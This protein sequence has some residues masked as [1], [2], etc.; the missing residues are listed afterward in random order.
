MKPTE[1]QDGKQD[2]GKRCLAAWFSLPLNSIPLDEGVT[3]DVLEKTYLSLCENHRP[4]IEWSLVV[5]AGP[6]R[7]KVVG[8]HSVLINK[9]GKLWDPATG[10]HNKLKPAYL[11]IYQIGGYTRHSV[12]ADELREWLLSLAEFYDLELTEKE[13]D[14][15]TS[16]IYFVDAIRELFRQ[17]L[18]I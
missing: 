16:N 10:F 17:K 7:P 4:N 15:I 5:V 1:L 6:F 18:S 14:D 12:S 8:Y 13:K 9:N 11:P 3:L 2:C